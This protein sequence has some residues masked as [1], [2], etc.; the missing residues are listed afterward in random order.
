MC[1]DFAMATEPEK[2]QRKSTSFLPDMLE[3]FTARETEINKIISYIKSDKMAVVSLHGEPG[4]GKTAIVIE[5]SHKLSQDAGTLVVFSSLSNASTVD[6]LIRQLCIDIG[7]NHDHEENQNPKSSLILWLKNIE[8][9]VIFLMD[10]VDSLL[11]GNT[12]SE[13]FS[14]ICL[15][16]RYSKQKGQIVTTSRTSYEI[17]KLSNAKVQVN[18]MT[19][20][21]CV[22]L[23]R[24]KCSE[25]DDDFLRR[26]AQLCGKIPLAMCIAA[27]QVADYAKSDE[28]LHHLE[29]QPMKTLGSSETNQYVNRAIKFSYDQLESKEKQAFV[30][31]AVF[32]GSFS[33]DA[34]R[35]VT[36]Q[37]SKHIL[38]NLVRRSLIKQQTKFRYSIHLLIKN[39]LKDQ[40]HSEG[41]KAE[42]NKAKL[43]IVKYYLFLAHDL[44]MKSYSNG[45][46][47]T[48]REALRDEAQNI[49]NVLKICCEEK[50]PISPI[51]I[52]L[53]DSKIF[54]SSARY[55]SLFARTVIPHSIVD[56]FLELCSKHA[57]EFSQHAIKI[58]FDC[59]LADQERL[60][61]IGK[62]VVDLDIKMKKIKQK[63]E[64]HHR[65][66]KRN[67]SLC[68][69][70]WYLQGRYLLRK[71][72]DLDGT[73]R[74]NLQ[75]EAYER[76]ENSLKIR[77]TLTHTAEGKADV[78]F[79]LLR[80]GN[81]AKQIA[82]S[83]KL[84]GHHKKF[85]EATTS[86]KKFYEEAKQLSQENLGEHD[87]TSSCYKGLGDL[88][89]TTKEHD[90]AIEMYKTAK[91][92]QK[93]LGLDASKGHVFLLNNLGQCF[94]EVGRA[95]EAISILD[96]ALDIAQKL[97]DNDELNFCQARVYRS[98][99]FA[100]DSQRNYSPDVANYAQKA[101]E[102]EKSN[103][104]CRMELER[105]LSRAAKEQTSTK[106][107]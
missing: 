40:P 59:L 106:T 58:N 18:E 89:L 87:L 71:S 14:F 85:T 83:E 24:N 81:T 95:N 4:F 82:T 88:F 19:D 32:N 102:F 93:V 33:E 9:K 69:H 36:E 75:I 53:T 1:D 103:T 60:R 2:G 31:L 94:T 3:T 78:V 48:N 76:L 51:S 70:Y 15:V 45:G 66:I 38:K 41:T 97:A 5:V 105:I 96:Y 100:Y 54:T 91:E 27:S 79:T 7:I 92:M 98:L 8:N 46:Y 13:F 16:R 67:K 10:D 107:C 44:T 49:Q 90:E 101:L 50:N 39:F 55:F 22:Q 12:M 86:A 99:A 65:R 68:A 62:P 77:K 84:I 56:D 42:N 47:K 73:R 11:R 20:E 25:Q 28:L 80:L 21:E 57:E 17:P 29:K 35:A 37:D 26:L 23:L 74:L 61:S 30:R 72:E 34:A 104:K 6:K 63:F 43:L 64:K 52:C